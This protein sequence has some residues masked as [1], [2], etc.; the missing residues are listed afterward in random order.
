MFRKPILTM[1]LAAALVVGQ[2]GAPGRVEAAQTCE[3]SPLVLVSS[4]VTAHTVEF[5]VS[6]P[7]S[8]TLVAYVWIEGEI[9]GEQVLGFGQFTVPANSTKTFEAYS[10]S[11]ITVVSDIS[12]CDNPPD[13]PSEGSDPI[14][15]EM[16]VEEKSN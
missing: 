12:L 4:L 16:E 8:T 3:I 5:T 9:G 11:P 15:V 13:G 1:T 7:T 10:P 14:I 6:N 2:V